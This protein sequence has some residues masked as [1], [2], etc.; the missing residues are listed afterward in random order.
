ML[1]YPGATLWKRTSRYAAPN[2]LK[3]TGRWVQTAFSMFGVCGRTLWHIVHVARCDESPQ[4]SLSASWGGGPAAAADLGDRPPGGASERHG[5]GCRVA[6]HGSNCCCERESR[7]GCAEGNP[8]GS[9]PEAFVLLGAH[10]TLLGA[11][12][13]FVSTVT[14]NDSADSS[15]GQRK[16]GVVL[17]GRPDA[18]RP[19][20]AADSRVRR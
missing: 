13:G 9:A 8:G 7:D 2:L 20:R 1:T 11:G 19:L 6:P 4:M 17:G 15:A 18:D 14:R 5:R 3:T 10:L 12:D 16:S